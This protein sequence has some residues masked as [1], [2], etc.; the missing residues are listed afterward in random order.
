LSKIK[1]HSILKLNNNG[2]HI[3]T[4]NSLRSVLSQIVVQKL[5]D[6]VFQTNALIQP[7][8]HELTNLL[9]GQF[10][11]DAVTADNQEFVIFAQSPFYYLRGSGDYLL[12]RF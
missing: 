8:F 5:T 12:L 1:I 10:L 9:V 11:P 7:L 4:A 2:G 3:I 6:G